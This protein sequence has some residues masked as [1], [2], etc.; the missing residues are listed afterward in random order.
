METYLNR[1]GTEVHRTDDIDRVRRKYSQK[2]RDLAHMKESVR[3]NLH[4]MEDYWKLKATVRSRRGIQGRS[5]WA[6][7]PIG[8]RL[9]ERQ[10]R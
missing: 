8:R 5:H 9:F 10:L 2:L 4:D 6:L 7:Y 1:H 3:S